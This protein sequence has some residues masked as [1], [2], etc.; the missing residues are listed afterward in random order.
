MPFSLPGNLIPRHQELFY[1]NPV[2]AGVRLPEIKETV[3]L[4][5]R[6]PKLS[7][8]VID[9]AKVINTFFFFF[10]LSDRE[11]TLCGFD[12][13]FFFPGLLDLFGQ[14]FPLTTYIFVH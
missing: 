9:L 4:E 7:E 13:L 10:N 2:F 11:F 5:R 1:K 14:Q 3:P 12:F 6:Y 8:V